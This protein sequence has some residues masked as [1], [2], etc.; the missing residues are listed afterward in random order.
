MVIL[1]QGLAQ[2][3]LYYLMQKLAKFPMTMLM[4]LIGCGITL[5]MMDYISCLVAI[6]MKTKTAGLNMLNPQQLI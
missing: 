1:E 5:L 3:G 2:L 6:L 4:I